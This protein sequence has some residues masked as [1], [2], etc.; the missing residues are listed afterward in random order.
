MNIFLTPH[1]PITE[2]T[3]PPNNGIP[4]FQGYGIRGALSR[5][6]NPIFESFR[7]IGKRH[8]SSIGS[9]LGVN[10]H[11]TGGKA[12]DISAKF[13]G[14]FVIQG[15]VNDGVGNHL[16]NCDVKLFRAVDD[17]II[18]SVHTD[19]N[20][21]FQFSLPNDSYKQYYFTVKRNDIAAS[22]ITSYTITPSQI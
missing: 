2:M 15:E 14:N 17:E 20:G 12:M 21:V 18:Q 13:V 11:K 5:F 7:D 1:C 8:P 22:A 9:E 16:S 3:D 19:A 6:K 10:V 4:T